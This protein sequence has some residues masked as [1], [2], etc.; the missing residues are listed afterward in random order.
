MGER[1]YERLGERLDER[2]GEIRVI[3]SQLL[4]PDR[5]LGLIL[6]GN[7]GSHHSLLQES[8]FVKI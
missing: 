8:I 5:G 1:L 7:V 4:S 3:L 2:L 6:K